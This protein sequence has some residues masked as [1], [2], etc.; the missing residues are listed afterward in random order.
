[1]GAPLCVLPE[2]RST[3][4][5]GTY[6]SQGERWLQSSQQSD[7]G[8]RILQ[9]TEGHTDGRG[10]WLPG[11]SQAGTEAPERRRCA[12]C[13]TMDALSALTDRNLARGNWD[14]GE[15]EMESHAT[16]NP[17]NPLVRCRLC[18]IQHATGPALATDRSPADRCN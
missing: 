18:G 2:S 6:C 15:D 12:Q 16:G 7:A 1:M 4:A 5:S 17:Q 11:S 14:R 13:H 3:S 10:V 9:S 8:V